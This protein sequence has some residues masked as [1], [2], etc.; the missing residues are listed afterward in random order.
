M[1]LKASSVKDTLSAAAVSLKLM[2]LRADRRL[3]GALEFLISY[4]KK[5]TRAGRNH[6]R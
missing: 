3:M 2:R 1:Q 5:K 6:L 4:H